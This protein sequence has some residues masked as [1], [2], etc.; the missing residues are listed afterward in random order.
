MLQID[1]LDSTYRRKKCASN[2]RAANFNHVKKDV[3]IV[4]IL[5][6]AKSHQNHLIGEVMHIFI[7]LIQCIQIM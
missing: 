4:L 7:I 5:P 2:L 6:D 1:G 3:K